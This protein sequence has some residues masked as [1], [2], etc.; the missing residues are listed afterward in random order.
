[1][2]DN[3]TSQQPSSQTNNSTTPS[4][5][6]NSDEPA[7][8]TPQ[9]DR[10]NLQPVTFH[11]TN[12]TF[13]PRRSTTINGFQLALRRSHRPSSRNSSSSESETEEGSEARNVSGENND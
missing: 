8:G 1:M 12:T 5:Q 10:N 9:A 6:S 13:T 4:T 11:T 2:V 7:T 3:T